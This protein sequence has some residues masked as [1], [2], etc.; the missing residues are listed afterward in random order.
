[1]SEPAQWVWSRKPPKTPFPRKNHVTDARKSSLV[2]YKVI[3]NQAAAS[4]TARGHIEGFCMWLSA[5]IQTGDEITIPYVGT[6]RRMGDEYFEF[7]PHP[8]IRKRIK[9]D[10][11]GRPEDRIEVPDAEETGTGAEPGGGVGAS[12]AESQVEIVGEGQARPSSTPSASNEQG[13]V[14]GPSDFPA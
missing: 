11:S 4:K 7:L 10:P 13:L 8:I 6:I 14:C 5:Q 9:N 2:A 1:M 12:E 3:H